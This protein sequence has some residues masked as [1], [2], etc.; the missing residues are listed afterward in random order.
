MAS[1]NNPHKYSHSTT[2][3][4]NVP[5]DFAFQYLKNPLHVGDWA[6]ACFNTRPSATIDGLYKG[7]PIYD[8]SVIGYYRVKANLEWLIVDL[9][10]GSKDVQYPQISIRIIPE[11]VCGLAPQ[12][13]YITLSAWRGTQRS[14]ES[15]ERCIALHEAGIWIIKCKLEADFA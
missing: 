5:A 10:I 12:S 3:L 8:E 13:C 7:T 11:E 6:L 4:V 2:Q 14:D 15:W 1:S 9:Y